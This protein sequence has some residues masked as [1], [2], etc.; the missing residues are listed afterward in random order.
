MC[1]FFQKPSS[2]GSVSMEQTDLRENKSI[3]DIIP[4]DNV[5]AKITRLH[6]E[7][8]HHKQINFV[9]SFHPFRKG[10]YSHFI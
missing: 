6:T 9:D 4:T 7:G 8:I 1:I 5:L 2:S 10:V 3:P